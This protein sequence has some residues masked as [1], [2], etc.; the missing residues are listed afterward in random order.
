M[1][2]FTLLLPLANRRGGKTSRRAEKNKTSFFAVFQIL[3]EDLTHFMHMH[4]LV[5][6]PSNRSPKEFKKRGCLPNLSVI[7]NLHK[8]TRKI[9]QNQN[10]MRIL[11][12]SK[13]YCK[14]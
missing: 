1:A 9:F 4:M 2:N 7:G 14:I 5:Y 8:I 12:M 6:T 13:P 11:K 10:I 3:A